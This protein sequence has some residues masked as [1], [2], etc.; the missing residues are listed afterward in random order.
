M[1]L[2]RVYESID[3]CCGCA[4]VC[5]GLPEGGDYDG[6]CGGWLFVSGD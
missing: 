4:H 2:E 6:D 1:V 3:Q 5:A